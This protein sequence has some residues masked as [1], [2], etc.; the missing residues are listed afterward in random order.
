MW[1][2]FNTFT[3]RADV[4]RLICGILCALL[5]LPSAAQDTPHTLVKPGLV[6]LEAKGTAGKAGHP[7]LGIP[8]GIVSQGTGFFVGTDGFIL[9]T[10]HFLDPLEEAEA[11]QV[12]F[13]ASIGGASSDDIPVLIASE[14]ERVDLLLL[15]AN[16][17]F[18]KPP[19]KPL[20][21]GR[22]STFDRGNPSPLFTSGFHGTHYRQKEVE[23]NRSENNDFP[24]AWEINTKSNSGQSGSPVY[25]KNGTVLGIVKG[26]ARSDDELTLMI[27]I[28][29]AMPLIGHL[30]IDRL[31]ERVELLLDI[32]GEMTRDDPPLQ[33]RLKGIEDN[34]SELSN[35]FTWSAHTA[36]DGELVVRYEKLISGGA[37]VDKIRIRVVPFVRKVG[38]DGLFVQPS[39]PLKLQ[40][41]NGGLVEHK[42]L[43]ADERIGE[44]VIPDLRDKLFLMTEVFGDIYPQ[45][46]FR[47][48]E[49][50]IIP[51]VDGKT[52]DTQKLTVIPTYEWDN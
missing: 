47:D 10:R 37:Q 9:T 4:T 25:D 23:F 12:T 20:T 33:E 36:P 7:K 26:T 13:A 1:R 17:P 38:S 42:V 6:Y 30:E 35:R 15:K 50:T 41:G 22:I 2:R 32:I 45:D 21:I 27:P 39:S 19:P 34:M 5:A 49:L 3:E 24:Y 48:L 51:E 31:N 43:D 44:F 52:L 40:T 11:R 14:L 46:P 29:F 8:S 16:M 18:D 28:D